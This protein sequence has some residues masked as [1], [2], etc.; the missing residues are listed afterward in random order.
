MRDKIVIKVVKKW[1]F[2][3]H[4]SKDNKGETIVTVILYEKRKHQAGL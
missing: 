4:F 3:Y 1:L 2:K